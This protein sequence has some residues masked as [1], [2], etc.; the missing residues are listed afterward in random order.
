MCHRLPPVG[1]GGHG[2]KPQTRE[3]L[4]SARVVGGGSFETPRE[5]GFSSQVG[6]QRQREDYVLKK[7]IFKAKNVRVRLIGL[8]G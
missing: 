8:F 7:V 3:T 1:L 4:P 2:S 5:G 6:G